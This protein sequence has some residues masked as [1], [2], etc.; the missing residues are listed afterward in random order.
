MSSLIIAAA[1]AGK[2]TF[3]V[4]QAL[5]NPAGDFV[6]EEYDATART[7]K[8]QTDRYGNVVEENKK[9]ISLMKVMGYKNDEIS[10]VVLNIY[11]PFVII[12]YLLS[13]PAMI[14][15]LKAIVKILTKDT[16]MSFPIEI[17]PFMAIVGLISLVVSYYIA[18]YLSRRA[19]NK[20]PLAEAL[21][22]E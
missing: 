15:I 4:E 7:Q 2:T 9:T 12:A 8:I 6:E 22:R 16:N 20:V 17:S 14:S 3:L 21:K 5:K 11:T 13:I 1:G 19:L 18:I 10:S